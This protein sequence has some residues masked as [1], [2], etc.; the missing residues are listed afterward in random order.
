MDRRCLSVSSDYCSVTFTL[1]LFTVLHIMQEY[2]KLGI[3]EQK[4]QLYMYTPVLWIRNDFSQIQ[5]ENL[6]M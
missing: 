6:A 4:V 1:T 2:N 3:H 5:S